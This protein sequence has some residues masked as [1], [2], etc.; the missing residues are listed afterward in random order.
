MLPELTL[1]TF[2]S[3]FGHPTGC[4]TNI[5][6]KLRHFC[7]FGAMFFRDIKVIEEIGCC[8]PKVPPSTQKGQPKLT[9]LCGLINDYRSLSN[10]LKEFSDFIHWYEQMFDRKPFI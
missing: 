5:A 10:Y 4:K 8:A 9:F 2:R 3:D 6:P 1:T 7:N